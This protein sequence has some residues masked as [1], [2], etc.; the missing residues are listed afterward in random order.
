MPWRGQLRN[1]R[2]SGGVTPTAEPD[3][4]R[5]RRGPDFV[6]PPAPAGPPQAPPPPPPDVDEPTPRRNTP[7]QWVVLGALVAV[8]LSF[9]LRSGSL[10]R[11]DLVFFGVL[12]PSIILHEVSHGAAALAFGDRTAQEAGRLTLNP[13]KHI[14]P[15]WTVLVPAMMVFY[16]GRAFGMAKPVPVNPGRMR[17]PRNHGMFTALAGPATNI[18]IAALTWVAY[19]AAYGDDLT[20]P[21]R[22]PDTPLLAEVLFSL[23]LANVVLAVFNM[24]PIPPLDGSAIVERILPVR[25][26]EPY[27][28]IRQF[29]FFLFIGLFLM[30]SDVFGR[31]LDPFIELWFRLLFT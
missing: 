3:E 29:S 1:G 5:R 9:A 6:V 15:F 7:V 24:I 22:H 13:L 26:L 30:G 19:R 23:G 8:A 28:R 20:G 31:I 17:S 18:A 25:L 14:D 4:P 12:I 16:T 11:A 27:L 2:Q 21:F 10:Q